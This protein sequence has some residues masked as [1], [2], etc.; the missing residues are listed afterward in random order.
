MFN[1]S[2]EI[3]VIHNPV[4]FTLFSLEI[5]W[6]AFGQLE[7]R[8]GHGQGIFSWPSTI[9]IL[10][11]Q[12]QPQVLV[13]QHIMKEMNRFDIPDFPEPMLAFAVKAHLQY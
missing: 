12:L 5:F 13:L 6:E 8:V 4:V 3:A 1:Q 11:P 9:A 2:I 10:W 7:R